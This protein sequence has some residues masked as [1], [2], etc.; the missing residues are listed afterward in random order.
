LQKLQNARMSGSQN[1]SYSY[2]P[3]VGPFYVLGT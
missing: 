3:L 2:I 1:P